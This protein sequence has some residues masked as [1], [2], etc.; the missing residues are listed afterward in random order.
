MKFVE[1]ENRRNPRKDYPDSVSSTT[2]P[3]WS[4]RDTNSGSQHWEERD[5][6]LAPRS[7]L[8][9]IPFTLIF[10]QPLR[11]IKFQISHYSRPT[12]DGGSTVTS[13]YSAIKES[14]GRGE[15]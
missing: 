2:K 11:Q 1:G 13:I 15:L 4:D 3:T 5:Q 7:H 6:L 8:Y 14:A 9:Y 12:C 10:A